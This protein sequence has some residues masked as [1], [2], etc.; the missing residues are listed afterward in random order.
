MVDHCGPMA[1]NLMDVAR[2]LP[3]IAGYNGLD[4]RMT[5]ESPLR[6]HV[7]DYAS[8]LSSFVGRGLRSNEKLG[9][10]MRIGLFTESFVVPGMSEAVKSTVHDAATKFFVA[11]G[12][13]IREIFLSLHLLGL[14][15]WSAAIRGSIAE[16][17]SKLHR[18][19]SCLIPCHIDSLDGYQIKKCMTCSLE[20]TLQ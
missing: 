12:V 11:S 18:L 3:V 2:L 10:G 8:E 20:I 17:G 14:A 15:I 16:L 6:E 13:T 4:P 19:I 9:T 1:T 5:P 7:K